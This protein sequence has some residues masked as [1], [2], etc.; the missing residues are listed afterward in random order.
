MNFK[1]KIY[2]SFFFALVFYSLINYNPYTY[3][4]QI[5]F[6]KETI[7]NPYFK[8]STDSLSKTLYLDKI[9]EIIIAPTQLVRTN[10]E[11]YVFRIFK[12]E[13]F[14]KNTFF[15][16]INSNK[17]VIIPFQNIDIIYPFNYFW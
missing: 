17:N 15:V 10:L 14:I 4:T 5:E 3:T 1:N 7:Q 9:H 16:L 2:I 8:D 13:S 12:P 11:H 6:S